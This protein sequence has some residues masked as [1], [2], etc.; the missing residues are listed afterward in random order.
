MHIPFT[1][2]EFFDVFEAYNLA[3]WPLQ[4]ISYILAVVALVSAFFKTRFTDIVVN[5]V[6]FL[7]WAWTGV[8]YHIIFFS[9]VNKA[10]FVFGL[11]FAIQSVMFLVSGVFTRKLAFR[12]RIDFYTS[13]GAIFI[14]YAMVIYPVLGYISGHAYPR[15]PS[16]GVTPCPVTIFTFGMLL[17][18]GKKMPK[19]VLV[20]P[21]VWSIIGSIA[22]VSLAVRED[23]G[24][25]VAGV[26]GTAFIIFR[27]KKRPASAG[28]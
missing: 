18:T 24:L 5:T 6:L 11:L 20:I 15:S 13:V 12:P 14:V 22:A 17:W 21:L 26:V 9:S 4:V 23:L 25:L 3:I 7:F 2:T 8:V 10:A 27:D 19:Y 1:L 16:F 28:E